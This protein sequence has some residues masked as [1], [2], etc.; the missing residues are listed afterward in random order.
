LVRGNAPGRQA[1][2]LAKP[3]NHREQVNRRIR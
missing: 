1:K 2:K 3:K